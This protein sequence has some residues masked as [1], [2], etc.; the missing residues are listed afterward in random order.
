MATINAT[1]PAVEPI[2]QPF[3][4]AN[5]ETG[6]DFVFK[7]A[8]GFRPLHSVSAGIVVDDQSYCMRSE[9]CTNDAVQL[10][11]L[12]PQLGDAHPSYYDGYN[13]PIVSPDEHRNI[14]YLVQL[15]SGIDFIPGMDAGAR[16]A[17]R[18]FPYS[19]FADLCGSSSGRT[20]Y[21]GEGPAGPGGVDRYQHGFVVGDPH[22]FRKMDMLGLS[23]GA[24][25]TRL[26]NVDLVRFE[27]WVVLPPSASTTRRVRISWNPANARNEFANLPVVDENLEVIETSDASYD[28]AESRWV[29]PHSYTLETA[30]ESLLSLAV[31]NPR[32]QLGRESVFPEAVASASARRCGA[33]R[34]RGPAALPARIQCPDR[35]RDRSTH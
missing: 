18:T 23:W 10:V 8:E 11:A 17:F 7:G 29:S 6:F 32:V 2:D 3:A 13:E 16:W 4:I 34:N 26:G 15:E 27:P 9:I 31:T 1:F 24:G 12:M 14:P 22:C 19:G 21:I 28:A 33:Q 30:A 25:Q 20:S 35:G 5:G